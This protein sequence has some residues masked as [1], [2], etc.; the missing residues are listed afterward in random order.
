[1]KI[2]EK[3]REGIAVLELS[4]NLEGGPDTEIFRD[5]LQSLVKDGIIYV[6]LDL[7][8]VKWINSTGLGMIISGFTTLSKAGGKMVLSRITEKVDA[9]LVMTKL[10]SIFECYETVDRALASLTRK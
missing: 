4:G 3:I 10:V 9:L 1:M 2:E 7:G 8:N 6:V 5:K